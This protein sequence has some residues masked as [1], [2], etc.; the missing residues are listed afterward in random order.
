MSWPSLTTLRQPSKAACA[1][2]MLC[3]IL[4]MSACAADDP[5]FSGPQAEEKLP[6]FPVKTVS[7]DDNGQMKLAAEA[8]DWIA[9]ANGKPTLLIVVHEVTRPAIGLARVLGSYGAKLE[10]AY[11]GMIVLTPAKS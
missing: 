9:E 7:F 11:V 1:A 3:L 5:V 6:P 10:G 2:A 4:T 8:V